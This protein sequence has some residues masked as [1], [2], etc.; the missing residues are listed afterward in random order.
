ML[1]WIYA[2]AAICSLTLLVACTNPEGGATSNTQKPVSNKWVVINGQE[3]FYSTDNQG[4]AGYQYTTSSGSVTGKGSIVADVYQMQGDRAVEFGIQYQNPAIWGQQFAFF[5][6]ENGTY[7]VSWVDDSGSN[8]VNA[9]QYQTGWTSS[10]AIHQGLN[11]LNV[12]TVGYDTS[13]KTYTFSINGTQVVS[14][15]FTYIDTGQVSF[16]CTLGSDT[17]QSTPYRFDF[18]LTSPYVV[19]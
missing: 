19:P 5:I 2:S 18:Q 14:E 13:A 17:S 4:Y 8:G 12:L 7:D 15:T 11:T 1:K 9:P 6:K 16:Y 10:S 3:V